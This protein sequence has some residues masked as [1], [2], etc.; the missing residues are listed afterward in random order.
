MATQAE[1]VAAAE[2]VGGGTTALHSH[3]GGGGATQDI[4][5]YRHVGTNKYEAW[6]TSPTTGT[7]LTTGALTANRLY[8]TPFICPTAITI[9]RI[10]LNV[11]TLLAGKARV[12][13]YTDSAMYPSG[14]VSGTDAAELDT[15]TAG[16]KSNTISV[17]L[18]A[19]TLYWLAIC[20]NAGVT[21]RCFAVASML[22]I[23]GLSNALG[24]AQYLGMYASYTYAALPA[25][26]PATPTMITS[27]PIPAV[28]VRLSA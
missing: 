24:T 1:L 12:G 11:T 14:L 4:S 7:A 23:L 20:T 9:D 2:L 15:G 16:V 21:V 19:N 8:A 25:N 10:G 18:S 17:G 3:S 28:F 5:Y 6:Y 13:I 22:P 27:T 26:Y